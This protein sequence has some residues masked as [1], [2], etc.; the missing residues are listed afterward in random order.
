MSKCDI[1]MRFFMMSI[2]KIV[3]DDVSDVEKY[4]DNKMN[5]DMCVFYNDITWKNGV[6]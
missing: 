4:D 6:L 3:F 1:I 5:D 2:E